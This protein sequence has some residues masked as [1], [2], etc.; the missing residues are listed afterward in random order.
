[1]PRNVNKC[2]WL[3]ASALTL[4]QTSDLYRVCSPPL[5][6]GQLLLAPFSSQPLMDAKL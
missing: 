6:Q 5:A 2:E 3:F 4:Q 1:M